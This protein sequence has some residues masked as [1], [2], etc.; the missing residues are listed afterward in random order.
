MKSNKGPKKVTYIDKESYNR[1]LF[2]KDIRKQTFAAVYTSKTI[3]DGFDKFEAILGK[4]LHK[5]APIKI[6]F[7]RNTASRTTKSI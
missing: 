2:T 3:D 4:C 6:K 5:Y 7:I 1:E